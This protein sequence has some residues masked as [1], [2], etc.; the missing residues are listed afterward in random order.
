MFYMDSRY[1]YWEPHTYTV[2]Q[3]TE[4]LNATSGGTYNNHY[5]E[6]VNCLQQLYSDA[7]RR[8]VFLCHIQTKIS[9]QH[10]TYIRLFELEG[11]LLITNKWCFV[12]S[13]R[14]PTNWQPNFAVYI[15]TSNF[16][17][18]QQTGVTDC[19]C[20]QAAGWMYSC[21]N[22]VAVCISSSHNFIHK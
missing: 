11:L 19:V 2:L 20:V 9:L 8:V 5:A 17:Q 13:W 15:C 1:L 12:A 18:S 7:N 22:R 10:N 3:N 4:Y 21:M 14:H 16:I 6:R